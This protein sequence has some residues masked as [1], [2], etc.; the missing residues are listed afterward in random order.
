VSEMGLNSHSCTDECRCWYVGK[1]EGIDIALALL[2]KNESASHVHRKLVNEKDV[3][4][5]GMKHWESMYGD[6]PHR[7]TTAGKG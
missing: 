6:N 2:D 7:S 5:K 1:Q 3:V 4:L